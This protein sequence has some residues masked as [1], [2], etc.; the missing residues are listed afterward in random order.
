MVRKWTE[1]IRIELKGWQG[2]V[3][4]LVRKWSEERGRKYKNGWEDGLWTKWYENGQKKEEGIPR[5]GK[6]N[7]LWTEWY[8]NGL[9]KSEGLYSFGYMDGSLDHL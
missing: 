8:E 3:D 2:G 6:R 1:K 4:Y 7:G 5:K 9:K